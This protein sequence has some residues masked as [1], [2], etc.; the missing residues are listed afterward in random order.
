MYNVSVKL[1]TGNPTPCIPCNGTG[2]VPKSPDRERIKEIFRKVI[3]LTLSDGY[4]NLDEVVDQIIALWREGA[5]SSKEVANGS[6]ERGKTD[7]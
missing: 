1:T 7:R 6:T 3:S 4:N 2:R 5:H